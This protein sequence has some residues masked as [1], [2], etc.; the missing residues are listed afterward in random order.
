MVI[1]GWGGIVGEKGGGGGHCFIVHTQGS[2]GMN[3]RPSSSPQ[4]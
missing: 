2:D 3:V 4:L 1:L